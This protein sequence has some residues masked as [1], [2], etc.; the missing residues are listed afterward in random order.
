MSQMTLL[1]E[2]VGVDQG[3]FP[4]GLKDINGQQLDLSRHN[5]WLLKMEDASTPEMVETMFVNAIAPFVLN[6]R[7]K[8][9]MLEGVQQYHIDALSM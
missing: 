6:A 4:K 1:P 3:V 8:P 7:V 2:D 9:L 5:S